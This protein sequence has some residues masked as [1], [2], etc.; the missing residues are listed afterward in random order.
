MNKNSFH[1][2]IIASLAGPVPI[3]DTGTPSSSSIVDM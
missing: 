1:F 2:L 3:Q